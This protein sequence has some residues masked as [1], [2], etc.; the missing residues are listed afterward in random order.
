MTG[1]SHSLTMKVWAQTESRNSKLG[2]TLSYVCQGL[3]VF[4]AL[5]GLVKYKDYAPSM[6]HP[7][8]DSGNEDLVDGSSKV[9]LFARLNL[10]LVTSIADA[11]F[12]S[13]IPDLS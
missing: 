11:D 8:K 13:L 7:V 9:T 2:A 3:N 5:M 10:A 4:Q 1:V 6:I 12:A